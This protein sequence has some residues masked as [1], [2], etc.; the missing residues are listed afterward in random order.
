VDAVVLD[1]QMPGLNGD[2][3]AAKMKA[4]K[5]HVPIML[6]S[7]YGPLPKIKLEP[8]DTFLSKS[9]PPQIL[10]STLQDLLNN[11]PKPFFNRWLDTWRS[12]N[13]GVRQ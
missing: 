3:V 9:Q 10:L 7:A 11:R 6:L 1:Y 13:E 4:L 5:S 8:V 2:V 12:R